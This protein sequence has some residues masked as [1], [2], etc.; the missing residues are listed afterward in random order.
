MF[1]FSE[2]C[3]VWLDVVCFTYVSQGFSLLF[4][5]IESPWVVHVGH[6]LTTSLV[7]QPST[8]WATVCV[9]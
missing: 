5:E 2:V 9:S 1:V 3:Y 6:E 7:P 4:F 8:C